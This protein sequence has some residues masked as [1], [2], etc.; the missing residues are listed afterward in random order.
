MLLLS[1]WTARSQQLFI[2]KRRSVRRIIVEVQ[3]DLD[4]HS[5]IWVEDRIQTRPPDHSIYG[6]H[7]TP[8][9]HELGAF[10][11]VLL[12]VAILMPAQPS[13]ALKPIPRVSLYFIR[14]SLYSISDRDTN[15]NFCR[16]HT[17]C[18]HQLAWACSRLA[19]LDQLQY[20]LFNL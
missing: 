7:G 9:R 19:Y 17:P 15:V 11:N 4:V 5:Y 1:L 18:R 8:V 13:S 2:A 14:V 20:S 10:S 6:T 12:I 3:F 16:C